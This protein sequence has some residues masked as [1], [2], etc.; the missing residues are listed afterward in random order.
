LDLLQRQ[1]ILDQLRDAKEAAEHAS[2]SKTVFLTTMSHEIRTPLNGVLGMASALADTTLIEE[3]AQ[4]LDVLR[5]SGR[6]LLSIV[7]DIL[8]LSKIEE[9]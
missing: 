7:D 8:D 4:I 2:R 3:Q 1:L 6:L 9:G 5:E